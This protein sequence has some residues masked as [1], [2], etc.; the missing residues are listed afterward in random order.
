MQLFVF[1]IS[2]L[3]LVSAPQK[4]ILGVTLRPEGERLVSQVEQAF[5]MP[6]DIQRRNS[7]P[8][9]STARGFVSD[10]G[11]PTLEIPLDFPISE[12]SILHEVLHLDQ[13]V[14][15]FPHGVPS[16]YSERFSSD[17]MAFQTLYDRLSPILGLY[18]T[19]VIEHS[20]FYPRLIQLNIDA[21]STSPFLAQKGDSAQKNRLP[22]A[23]PRD[24]AD[25]VAEHPNES[26]ALW[27]F[28]VAMEAG[29][30][31]L[32]AATEQSTTQNPES[33]RIGK[34]LVRIVR[35]RNPQTPQEAADTVVAGLNCLLGGAAAF[36]FSGWEDETAEGKVIVKRIRVRVDFPAVKRDVCPN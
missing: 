33:L 32:V 6:I 30:G 15:G 10:L 21:F 19:D 4:T 31:N 28:K 12:E 11:V 8:T 3:L 29:D 17:A 9:A 34:G 2:I 5:G 35:S 26:L 16:L 7:N 24:I 25:A 23:L 36:S 13:R 27:Y 1:P 18:F 14:R 20:I 22:N